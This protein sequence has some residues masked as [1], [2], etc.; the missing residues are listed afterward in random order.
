MAFA[1]L[2]DNCGSEL[3]G[4][5]NFIQTRGTISDQ[6]EPGD[7][8]VEFRYLTSRPEEVHTFCD[9]ACEMQWR[10]KKRGQRHFVSRPNTQP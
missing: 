5:L 4:E 2:C 3:G 8:Y 9:D 6:Y 1:K 7:G 10:D